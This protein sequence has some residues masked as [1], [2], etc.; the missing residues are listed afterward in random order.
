LQPN[1]KV[2]YKNNSHCQQF[3][4]YAANAIQFVVNAV[5]IQNL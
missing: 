1:T 5:L 4:K 3:R 2:I